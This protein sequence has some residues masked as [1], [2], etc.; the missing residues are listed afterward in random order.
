[1]IVTYLIVNC[2]WLEI[3]FGINDYGFLGVISCVTDLK[4]S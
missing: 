4:L 2:D 1:M 3:A